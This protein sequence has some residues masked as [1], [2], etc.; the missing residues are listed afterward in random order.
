MVMC[1]PDDDSTELCTGD[2]LAEKMRTEYVGWEPRFVFSPVIGTKPETHVYLSVQKL[3][4]LI[5]TTVNWTLMDCAPLN[6]WIH[7]DGKLVLLGDA[8]HPM[9]VCQFRVARLQHLTYTFA[10]VPCARFGHGCTYNRAQLNASI[11]STLTCPRLKM[12]PSSVTF[13]RTCVTTARSHLYCT[14]TNVSVT[15]AQWKHRL[16]PG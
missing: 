7:Q 4:S 6:T 1:H 8:C 14:R 2:V 10:A 12:P 3:L 13:S 5:P 15:F 11:K 16:H 9:L